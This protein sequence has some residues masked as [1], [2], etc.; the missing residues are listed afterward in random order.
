MPKS[1]K[2]VLELDKQNDNIFWKYSITKDMK[3]LRVAFQILNKNE[4]VS[5]GFKFIFFVT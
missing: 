5:I 2:H 3:N 1:A 4:E